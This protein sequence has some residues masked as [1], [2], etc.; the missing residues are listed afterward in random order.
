M[1]PRSL[2]VLLLGAILIDTGNLKPHPQGKATDQDRRAAAILSSVQQLSSPSLS[3]TSSDSDYFARLRE[4]KSDVSS[5][6]LRDHFRRDYKSFTSSNGFTVGLSSVL[7][8]I[9]GLAAKQGWE[10]LQ[11]ALAKWAQERDLDLA[12]VLTNF[13]K[14]DK[15]CKEVLCLPLRESLRSCVNELPGKTDFGV[16]DLALQAWH[17]PEQSKS[18]QL[19]SF[20]Q[21]NVKATRKQVLPALRGLV[22]SLGAR[23]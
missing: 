8:G 11:E 22:E 12:V 21:G 20:Q 7:V 4:A 9:E 3:T 15:T 14:G 19:S 23:T 6:S 5:L 13:R 16:P 1:L 18:P 17:S 10:A 2:A